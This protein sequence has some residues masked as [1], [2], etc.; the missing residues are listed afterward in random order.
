MT[1]AQHQTDS[2]EVARSNR[3][4][5]IASLIAG[6]LLFTLLV[7]GLNTAIRSDTLP[8]S[9]KVMSLITGAIGVLLFGLAVIGDLYRRKTSWKWDAPPWI[10]LWVFLLPAGYFLLMCLGFTVTAADPWA[11]LA[12]YAGVLVL[13]LPVLLFWQG[14]MLAWFMLRVKKI[15]LGGV[16]TLKVP[17]ATAGVISGLGLALAAL[18]LLSIQSNLFPAWQSFDPGF[19]PSM[20]FAR[21]VTLIFAITL[22]PWAEEHYFRGILFDWL[23]ERLGGAGGLAVSAAL[24]ALLPLRINLFFPLVVVG[25]GLGLLRGRLRVE[26]AILAHAVCN[27]V[28]LGLF[29]GYM[30]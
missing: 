14:V 28:I 7:F 24:F 13:Q 11:D 20:G 8:D 12:R 19:P 10:A 17:E 16:F 30:L 2:F 22:L 23:V 25:F 3:R 5:T 15:P 27:L 9:L 18:F 21:G 29:S 1:K 4:A 26:T 6:V